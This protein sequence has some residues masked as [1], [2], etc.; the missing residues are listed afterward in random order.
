MPQENLIYTGRGTN[1]INRIRGYIF[2]SFEHIGL[3][4]NAFIY[5]CEELENS[6]D[7]Y[8]VAGAAMAVRGVIT[9]DA[10][11]SPYLCK[12]I[13]N[14][15]VKDNAITFETYKPQGGTDH[16]TSATREILLTL[17]WLGKAG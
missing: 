16:Y 4:E 9:P 14:I 12:A 6:S 17:Q 7:P 8:V 15:G 11:F 10:L 2:A 5:V 3:P 1:Q 13:I